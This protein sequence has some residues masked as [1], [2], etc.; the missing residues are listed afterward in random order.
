M[1]KEE[2]FSKSAKLEVKN[3]LISNM[4]NTKKSLKIS[5]VF[6]PQIN[7]ME[8]AQLKNNNSIKNV[9]RI[10]YNSEKRISVLLNTSEVGF[11]LPALKSYSATFKAGWDEYIAQIS[12]INKYIVKDNCLHFFHKAKSGDTKDIQ[13]GA[14]DN[15][16]LYIRVSAQNNRIS[17]PLIEFYKFMTVLEE[18]N[19]ECIRVNYTNELN[20]TNNTNKKPYNKPNMY[21]NVNVN[22]KSSTQQ[23]KDENLDLND[24]FVSD[25]NNNDLIL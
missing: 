25:L 12:K 5:L 6:T 22:S 11:I 19:K 20:I 17:F 15:G 7:E 3:V 9:D 1:V 14:L 23:V 2:F 13:I 24:L 18:A 16:A 10:K 21:A 4:S 8:R